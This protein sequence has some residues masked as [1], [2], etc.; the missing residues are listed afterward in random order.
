VLTDEGHRV[1]GD[2]DS[3]EKKSIL[4]LS[5]LETLSDV[6]YALVL[7]RLFTLFP[8]PA[9]EDWGRET[10][11]GFF[12]DELPAF[13][14]VAI[15]LAFTIIYWLQSNALLGDL[16]RTDGRHTVLSVVQIFLLLVFLK[17]VGL[18]VALEPSAG[19]RAMEGLAAASVGIAG[20]W[21]WSY[22]I[23][24]R[25]LLS[26]DVSDADALAM[27]DRITAEPLTALFTLLF[28]FFPILWELSWFSYPIMIRL[29]RRRRVRE[30][31]A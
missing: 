22:A 7:W 14:A 5:R 24:D 19:V 17:V 25:R 31:T 18:S 1:A 3:K 27:R 2:G 12:M 30:A 23:K 10:I 9:Q 11:G 26:P 6:V 21:A 8:S 4:Q 13:V 15:G 29:V 16:E 28:A 20:A